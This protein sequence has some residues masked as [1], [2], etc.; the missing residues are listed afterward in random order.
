MRA[1]HSWPQ[2]RHVYHATT[3]VLS[4]VG[5]TGRPQ[6]GHAIVAVA[7]NV[8]NIQTPSATIVPLQTWRPNGLGL[9]DGQAQCAESIA[10]WEK[11][12]TVPHATCLRMHR[13]GGEKR[14]VTTAP[15]G[16]LG[17]SPGAAP[18]S[19]VAG[20]HPGVPR[21]LLHASFAF[22]F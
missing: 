6:R 5:S 13:L 19:V 8:S 9:L 16:T 20:V 7:D 15:I 10:Q 2:R 14:L 12:R 17:A 11:L 4:A 18:A 21:C 3:Q 1:D 22:R